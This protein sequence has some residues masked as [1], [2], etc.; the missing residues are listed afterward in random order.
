MMQLA[1]VATGV[2]MAAGA[3][4]GALAARAVIGDGDPPVL[5]IP[6]PGSVEVVLAQTLTWGLPA[7]AAGYG[8]MELARLG[9]T[10]GARVAAVGAAALFGAGI[11]TH[12]TG[13]LRD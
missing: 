3:I 4:G 12:F 9:H 5:D 1:N 10:G 8:A 7:V 13:L 6:G 11:V 2:A